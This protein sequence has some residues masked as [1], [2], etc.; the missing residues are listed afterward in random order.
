MTETGRKTLCAGGRRDRSWLAGRC[1][2]GALLIVAGGC[3][4]WSA[5]KAAPPQPAVPVVWPEPPAAPR[6]EFLQTVTRHADLG[7]QR[8]VW[9]RVVDLVTGN[10]EMRLVRPEGV[11]AAGGRV[12]VADAGSGLVYRYDLA[13]GAVRVF[14]RCGGERFALPVAVAFLDGRLYVSDSAGARI[15]VFDESGQCAGV[16]PTGEGSRPAGL[17]ADAA[18]GRLYVADAGHHEVVVFDLGG[19]A[20]QRI[21]RRGDAAGEFN[22]PGWLALGRNGDLYVTDAL[23][24]RIQIFDAEGRF[25]SSFGQHGDGSG[26]LARPKGIGVDDTGH[27]FLADA[28]FDAVQLFDREGRYLMAFGARGSGAGQFWLP[29][30]VAVDG[31]RIYVADSFNNR[32]QVFRFLG[33]AP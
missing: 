12:A 31:D 24:F 7:V 33:G 29:S 18:R 2:A 32:V 8:S 16:W 22:F 23:N 27:I 26:H 28:L 17:A 30:D 11:A 25:V 21:G 6:V 9:R 3:G 1:L 13:A 4:A 15:H 14:E 19:H 20:V 5:S 10:G